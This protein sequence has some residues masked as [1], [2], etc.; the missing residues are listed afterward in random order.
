MKIALYILGLI[1]ICVL[2]YFVSYLIFNAVVSS[3]LP[4]FWKWVFLH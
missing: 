3:D 1:I 2:V 4:L